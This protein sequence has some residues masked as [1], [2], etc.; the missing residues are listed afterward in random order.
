MVDWLLQGGA[1][2]DAHGAW[3][4]TP[5][6]LAARPNDID[7]LSYLLKHGATVSAEDHFV[8]TPIQGAR[9]RGLMDYIELLARYETE[10][11]KSE[12]MTKESCS[13]PN[14]QANNVTLEMDDAAP[15]SLEAAE[16]PSMIG[17]T[18]PES[19]EMPGKPPLAVKL[20]TKKQSTGPLKSHIGNAKRR[21]LLLLHKGIRGS[22]RASPPGDAT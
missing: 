12:R 22:K 7:I 9:E 15:Q 6:H 11:G 10:A 13:T 21:A 1:N 8:M 20:K 4:R 3:N 16:N 14:A 2:I 17:D 19:P 5:L 18:E